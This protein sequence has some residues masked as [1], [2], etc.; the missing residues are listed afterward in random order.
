MN[1]TAKWVIG[2][3]IV[4]VI[5]VWGYSAMKGPSVPVSTEPI[6]I[7]AIV[8]LTGDQA[9]FGDEIKNS[10]LLANELDNASSLKKVEVVIEDSQDNPAT[11][12]SAYNK[13][14]LENIPAIISTGDQVSYALSPIAN[15]DKVVLLMTT[16]AS[17]N[18]SGDYAFRGFIT[19]EQQAKIMGEYATKD[20]GIKKIGAIYINNIYGESYIKAFEDAVVSNNGH[21]TSKEN[22]G[23]AD[24][25]VKTQI[26]KTLKNNPDVISV[27]GFGPAYPLIFKQ[28]RELGWKGVIL[29]D[30]T[31]TN[32]FFFDAIGIENLGDTYF[33]STN[34]DSAIPANIQ[35]RDFVDKYKTKFGTAP[36]YIGAF[37]FDS[38]N[39][40]S[41]SIKECGYNAENIK[42][43]LLKTKNKQGLLGVI[44][45]STHEMKV[46]LYVKKVEGDKTIIK[47]TIN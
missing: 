40:L 14:R 38:Y 10:L 11:A 47:K 34:F 45:F 6:K 36:G 29:A 39:V 20:L 28:L 17:Q 1:K 43:C 22:Y 24:N 35:T 30:T 33:T 8:F 9:I 7:G 3:V 31:L 2:I 18:I 19:A 13:L 4:L 41:A 16:V 21:L 32:P 37:A 5:V 15:K 44:D 46:P 25:D 12:V 23:I 26:L 42:D 27:S